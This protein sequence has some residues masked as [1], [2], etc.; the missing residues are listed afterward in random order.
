MGRLLGKHRI[1]SS[2]GFAVGG[3]AS[4]PTLSLREKQLR[5]ICKQVGVTAFQ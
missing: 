5:A 3:G 1:A 4:E 2:L